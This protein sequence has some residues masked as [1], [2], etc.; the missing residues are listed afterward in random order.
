MVSHQHGRQGGEPDAPR[1]PPDEA[2]PD[3]AAPEE[4]GPDDAASGEAAPG[5][6]NLEQVLAAARELGTFTVDLDEADLPDL[7]RAGGG[8]GRCLWARGELR[9][10]GVG[11]A[12]RVPLPPGWAQPAHTRFV[13]E[14]LSAIAA[15]DGHGRSPNPDGGASHGALAGTD[16]APLGASGTPRGDGPPAVRGGPVA[17][18]ALPYDPALAGHLSIPR[19]LI[20]HRSERPGHGD[21]PGPSSP[22]EA[23]ATIVA[24]PAGPW[25]SG[26][27]RELVE[28]QL[29]GLREENHSERLPDAFEL[30]AKMPHDQWERLVE[31]AVSEMR[32]GGL[33][34]V[35]LA[36]RVDVVANRPFAVHEALARLAALYPSCTVFHVEG[37]IGASP[38]TLV[39][40][41]GRD[42]MSNPLAGTVARSGDDA[43]DARL[44]AELMAS[45]KDRR[46]H[47]LVVDAIAA[48]LRPVCASLDI[49]A[50]PSVLPLR[51]VSHLGTTLTGA[52]RAGVPAGPTALDLAALLQPTPAVGGHPSGRA[53]RWQ[54]DNEGFERGVY[55][56]PVGWMDSHG[57]GEWA[58]G[59]RCAHVS[60]AH[61]SLYAGNGIVVGSDPGAELAETQ[62]KLQALLAALV[63]P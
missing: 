30:V 40:R 20:G 54:R 61:A 51:N 12:L 13:S 6:P 1:Q 27:G 58:L 10:L 8:K 31:K 39:R 34:K 44:L 22:G 11:E 62:L 17:I 4:A 3:E 63:R 15:T 45:A 29:L 21:R 38:E 19:L 14:V 36:R 35:V 7:L 18:G 52:L 33:D 56:G 5:A 42:I 43:T 48:Q 24:P 46:E 28:E 49:P 2:A 50:A 60:G 47:Q 9:L 25:W 37:F 53:L 32:R 26:R 16:G 41:E 23:W 59:L 55:A 57:N